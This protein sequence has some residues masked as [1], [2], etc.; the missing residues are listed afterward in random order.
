MKYL[1]IHHTAVQTTGPQLYAVDRYH[2]GKWNMKSSLGWFVGYNYFIDVDGTITNTRK[3]GE[4]TIAQI[5]H[6]CTS[7]SD[8][9]TISVCVAG[10]FDV[11]FPTDK[12]I[13]SLKQLRAQY[14]NLE[15]TM[16][17]ALQAN[18]TC[19]G[20]NIT[21][22]YLN[23]ALADTSEPLSE[24]EEKAKIKELTSILDTLRGIYSKL[25]ANKK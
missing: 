19:P 14:P 5:G 1:A 13:A 2:Q 12:Q 8:C 24:D 7:G 25:L 23:K 15:L 20:K 10:N 21:L 22:D 6:N 11:Y 4:E 18:R 3:A 16:H 17:R 9:D